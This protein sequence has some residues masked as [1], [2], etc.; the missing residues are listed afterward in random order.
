M[1]DLIIFDLDGVLVDSEPISTRVLRDVL[2][3]IG[4][5]LSESA[6]EQQF[7]GRS[8]WESVAMIEQQLGRPV[9]ERFVENWQRRVFDRLRQQLRPV[10]GIEAALDRLTVP[11]CLASGS[12]PARIQLS[13]EVTGL[14][15]RFEGRIFSAAQVARGKPAPDLFLLAAQKLGAAPS[16]CIVVEDSDVGIEAAARAGMRSLRFTDLPV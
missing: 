1:I 16:E 4:L 9:P 11:T 5:S 10:P 12:D 6:T 14:L 3:E 15:S 13:L 7:L 8:R 2:A